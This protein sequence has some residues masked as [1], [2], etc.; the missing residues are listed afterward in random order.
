MGDD[1]VCRYDSERKTVKN[2][3][4]CLPQVD[5]YC[6]ISSCLCK[7]SITSIFWN[8][9]FQNFSRKYWANYWEIK[10]K[11]LLWDCPILMWPVGHTDLITELT[12][13]RVNFINKSFLSCCKKFSYFLPTRN[14]KNKSKINFI[15]NT[16]HAT[17][18]LL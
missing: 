5:N 17:K 12:W 4:L 8:I 16:T 11:L 7:A 14:F 18:I 13:S 10:K 15:S 3:H 9:S 1:L 2:K 6:R